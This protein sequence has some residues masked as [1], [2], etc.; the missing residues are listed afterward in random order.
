MLPSLFPAEEFCRDLPIIV[1]RDWMRALKT[2]LPL[3]LAVDQYRRCFAFRMTGAGLV[4]GLILVSVGGMVDPFLD[5]VLRVRGH[6]WP[7]VDD[8]HVR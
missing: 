2:M 6:L 8:C 1:V 7:S 4:N 5:A 3:D